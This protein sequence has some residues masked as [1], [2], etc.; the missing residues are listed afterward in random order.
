MDKRHLALFPARTIVRDLRHYESPTRYKQDFDKQK[1]SLNVKN[2]LK[3]LVVKFVVLLW[4]I[5]VF[6][7]FRLINS[8][9]GF[10]F[11]VVRTTHY[12]ICFLNTCLHNIKDLVIIFLLYLQK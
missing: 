10:L 6:Y 12:R 4:L 7:C 5:F 9:R 2:A 1:K 3:D 11:F 8:Q